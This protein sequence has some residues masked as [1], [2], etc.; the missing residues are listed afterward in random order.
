M[1][2]EDKQIEEDSI[3]HEFKKGVFAKD[4]RTRD[5]GQ[6]CFIQYMAEL[7]TRREENY[8]MNQDA[9]L[10][11]TNRQMILSEDVFLTHFMENKRLLAEADKLK[12]AAEAKA[13]EEN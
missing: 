10:A 5:E 2:F 8:N 9:F 11:Q 6:A 7:K 1:K 3:L 12:A 4:S 13:A